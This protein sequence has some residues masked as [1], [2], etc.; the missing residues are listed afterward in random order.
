MNRQE[1]K[2]MLHNLDFRADC[3]DRESLWRTIS[4][5]I[6]LVERLSEQNEDL[7]IENQKLRDENNRLKGEQGKPNILGSKGGAKNKNVSSEKERKERIERRRKSRRRK[8][9]RYELIGRKYVKSTKPSC[10]QMPSLKGM[11][12][13]L[14]RRF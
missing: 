1:V 3:S 14:C 5:L 11:R 7:K 12:P 13:L 10:Q 4:I 9:K 8:R 2:E 6:N